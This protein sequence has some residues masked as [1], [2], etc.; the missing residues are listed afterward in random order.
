MYRKSLAE[1]LSGY[2][3]DLPPRE[4]TINELA[5]VVAEFVERNCNDYFQ[6]N[7]KWIGEGAR[8]TLVTYVTVKKE[9]HSVV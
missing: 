3:K 8:G 2:L 6:T 9:E 4:W 7:S 5:F 1:D